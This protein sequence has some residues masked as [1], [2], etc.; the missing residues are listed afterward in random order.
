[1][2]GLF[3]EPQGS[4]GVAKQSPPVRF[5]AGLSLIAML[6]FDA[7]IFM[8][9][10]RLTTLFESVLDHQGPNLIDCPGGRSFRLH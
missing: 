4:D 3:G 9:W 2:S 6:K 7:L 8:F 10:K 1:M 5:R